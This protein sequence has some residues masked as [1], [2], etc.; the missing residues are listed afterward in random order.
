MPDVKR[1]PAKKPDSY[2]RNG[3]RIL[4]HAAGKSYNSKKEGE[5]S[6]G[7]RV[8]LDFF[9]LFFPSFFIGGWGTAGDGPRAKKRGCPR[10]RTF[11]VNLIE[12]S[13][14]GGESA[15][16][17]SPSY[18]EGSDH[19]SERSTRGIYGNQAHTTRAAS[20][21]PYLILLQSGFA[22]RRGSRQRPVVSYTTLSPFPPR[23]RG[24]GLFSVALSVGA[25]L[26]AP[27]RP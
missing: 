19:S 5:G 18:A 21:A 7:Q 13:R 15:R 16:F 27:L 8:F 12:R 24:G 23:I 9:A 4:E 2:T 20:H 11:R 25:D 26:A 3:E 10:T 14:P 17:C 22:V 6:R 1:K